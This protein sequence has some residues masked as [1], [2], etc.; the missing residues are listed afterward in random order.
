MRIG[1]QNY[2]KFMLT[3]KNSKN[4]TPNLIRLEITMV[5]GITNLGKYT[6]PKIPALPTKTLEVPPN[7]LEK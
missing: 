1:L 3:A 7:E 4:C 5:I 2:Q 6:L